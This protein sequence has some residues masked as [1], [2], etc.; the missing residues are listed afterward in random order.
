MRQNVCTSVAGAFLCTG[1]LPSLEGAYN[2]IEDVGG[3][4]NE[5]EIVGQFRMAPVAASVVTWNVLSKHRPLLTR[6]IVLEP[7]RALPRCLAQRESSGMPWMSDP[8]L[9]AP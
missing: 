7:V 3:E 5:K 4:G 9:P 8:R 1:C 6:L 2:S